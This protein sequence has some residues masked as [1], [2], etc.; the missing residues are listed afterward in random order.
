MRE[1]LKAGVSGVRGVVGDS[2]TPQL[3]TAFAQAFGTFVGRGTVVVGRDTRVTGAM[4][5]QAVIAGLQSVG[6]RPLLAGVIP[7]PTVLIL[8]REL[9]ARGGIA[10][11]ASHNPAQWNAL[12]FVDRNGLFLNEI[13]AEELLDVYHQQVF[14]LVSEPEIPT[15][16]R[17]SNPTETH[18]RRIAEY[19]DLDAIRKQRF[20]VALDCCNGV[21]AVHSVPFL[22]D[23]LGCEVFAVLD[24]P[25]GRFEREPEP[26]PDHLEILCEAVQAHQCDVGFAQDPDGD[27][28]ALINERGE[29]LGED[30]T[31]A[32][33]VEQVLSAHG[34]GPVAVNLA[35]SKSIEYVANRHG[36]EVTRT[37]IGE[38]NVSQ[39]MLELGA[40]VGG[41]G[42]GGVIVP[43]MHPC[44]DSYVGM[45]L[46]L[47]L[48]AA[49]N[50][51]VSV[52][53]D[54]IPRYYMAKEKRRIRGERVPGVLRGL[55]RLYE[56][57]NPSMLDGVY[58]DYGTSWINARRSNTE[59]VIRLTAEAPSPEEASALLDRLR[60]QI[61]TLEHDGKGEL[62]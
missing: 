57:Q 37:R 36:C 59:P 16:K 21:G 62:R 48:L 60:D 55:R 30:L 18:W 8:T 35:T 15:E 10:I 33:A 32:L 13:Q 11:T 49:R 56:D 4:V 14:A 42:N 9:G 51:R 1:A 23:M 20:R 7:T 61:R 24:Q 28:L 38:I 6:C 47:E 40:V 45:A 41:E 27:R 43:A 26:T 5:E 19:V 44:R 29:P 25:T 2:F 50:E 12:K 39:T 17:V 31:L 34:K 3:A 58:V 53:R 46:I 52:L 54:A 22:R